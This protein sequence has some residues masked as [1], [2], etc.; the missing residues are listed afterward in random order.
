MRVAVAVVGTLVHLV[1]LAAL[2]AGHRV[3]VD[4]AQEIVELLILAAVVVVQLLLAQIQ[5]ELAVLE[6]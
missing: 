5:E 3:L 1:A 2:E 4:L 6:L